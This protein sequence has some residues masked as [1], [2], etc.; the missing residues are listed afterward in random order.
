MRLRHTEAFN[1]HIDY[2][3]AVVGLADTPIKFDGWAVGTDNQRVN[4]R[5][6]VVKRG[7]I[8]DLQ[9]FPGVGADL[10]AVAR[11]HEVAKNLQE[12]FLL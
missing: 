5:F 12:L 4:K 10:V 11:D 7:R 1:D 6:L 8:L 2:F 3:L 9:V